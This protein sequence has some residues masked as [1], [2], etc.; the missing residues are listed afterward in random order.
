M[1]NMKV[2]TD[3]KIDRA[4]ELFMNTIKLLEIARWIWLTTGLPDD[5]GSSYADLLLHWLSRIT[6]VYGCF[7]IFLDYVHS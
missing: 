7:G 5:P 6:A 1:E 4:K 2:M 3:I